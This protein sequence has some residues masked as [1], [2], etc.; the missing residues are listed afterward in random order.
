MIRS[1]KDIPDRRGFVTRIQQYDGA[2]GISRTQSPKHERPLWAFVAAFL[3]G[4]DSRWAPSQG[5]IQEL[6]AEHG[7]N[8]T[9]QAIGYALRTM[10]HLDASIHPHRRNCGVSCYEAVKQMGGIKVWGD[11]NKANVIRYSFNSKQ[12]CVNYYRR[13][14][15]LTIQVKP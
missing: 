1:I 6:L 13:A 15:G 5:D 14:F 7:M 9:V 3:P 12:S 10:I 4:N 2:N 11:L 8:Y